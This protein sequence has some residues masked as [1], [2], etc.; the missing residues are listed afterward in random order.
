M[1]IDVKKT[2]Q[3]FCQVFSR[4]VDK[5]RVDEM[6]RLYRLLARCIALIT[7]KPK[8]VDELLGTRN[9]EADERKRINEIV[10]LESDMPQGGCTLYSKNLT[11]SG[12]Y[13]L[14]TL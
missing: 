10:W 9:C 14:K 7:L 2:W 13:N 8:I 5:V 12:P 11:T 6:I 1:L 3:R 4:Q